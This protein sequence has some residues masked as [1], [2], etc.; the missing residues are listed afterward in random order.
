MLM[1]FAKEKEDFRVTM[2]K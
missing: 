2:R 1:I